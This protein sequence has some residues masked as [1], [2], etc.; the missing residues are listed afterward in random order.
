MSERY[1]VI[2]VGGGAAGLSAALVL[3]RCRRRVRLYDDGQH[4]NAAAHEIHC[5]L[6]QEGTPPRELYATARAEL[7][8][9]ETVTL[10]AGHVTQITPRG[11]EFFV[12]CGDGSTVT[13]RKGATCCWLPWPSLRVLRRAWQSIGHCDRGRAML[14]GKS[15]G[16]RLQRLGWHLSKL[17]YLHG[18]GDH[19]YGVALRGT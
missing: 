8:R 12:T 6:G 19:G 18:G 9:Y 15:Q 7:G 14:S 4:R 16:H 3:G 5:L 11:N 13:A 1:D 17:R 2:I 10:Y